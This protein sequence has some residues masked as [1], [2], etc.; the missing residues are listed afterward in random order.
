M[1]GSPALSP[2]PGG[3]MKVKNR[4]R[5]TAARSGLTGLIGTAIGSFCGVAGLRALPAPYET[6]VNKTNVAASKMRQ[7]IRNLARPDSRKNLFK[8]MGLLLLR[9]SIAPRVTIDRFSRGV[10]RYD[11]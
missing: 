2:T 5:F 9:F 10:L 4:G 3:D 11:S 7:A 1:E 6:R 8:N